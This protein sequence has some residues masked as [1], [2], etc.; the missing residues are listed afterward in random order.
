VT[1]DTYER[2]AMNTL[3][4]VIVFVFVLSVVA[5]V[6]YVLFELSPFAHHKESFR[7]P[8]TGKRRWRSPRLD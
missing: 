8:R 1:L 6:A 3:F 7:D 2:K 4:A 5:F